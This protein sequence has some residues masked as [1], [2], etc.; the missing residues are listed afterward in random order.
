MC[1]FFPGRTALLP[2]VRLRPALLLHPHHH[3]P[4]PDLWS[5]HRHLRRPQIREAVQRRRAE[6][7]LLRMRLL[8][9]YL[10]IYFVWYSNFY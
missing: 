8:F 3:R 9:I 4:Q 10:I 2:Q 1:F 7:H 6:E 5:D